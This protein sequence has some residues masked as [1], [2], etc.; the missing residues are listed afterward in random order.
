M[1]HEWRDLFVMGKKLRD[2]NYTLM[3][4]QGSKVT[5]LTFDIPTS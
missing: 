5:L 3:V 4:L 2:Q 1:T